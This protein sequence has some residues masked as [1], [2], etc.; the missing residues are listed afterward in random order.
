MDANTLDLPISVGADMGIPISTN[1]TK[2]HFRNWSNLCAALRAPFKTSCGPA[3]ATT[4]S[5]GETNFAS[6]P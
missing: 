1:T 5:E 3:S 2:L 6:I 4:G